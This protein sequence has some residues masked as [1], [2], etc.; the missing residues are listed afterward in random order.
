MIKEELR[1]GFVRL[2]ARKGYVIR[3]IG[4]DPHSEITGITVKIAD[5]DNYE[6]APMADVPPY[7]EAERKAKTVELIRER[8]DANKEFEVQRELLNAL[9]DPQAMTLDETGEDSGEPEAVRA[10]REYNRY[11]EQCIARAPQAVIAEKRQRKEAEARDA[12]GPDV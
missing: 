2:I 4:S 3:K 6:E 12:I 9:L 10:Y 8:Y 5:V 11:V 1:G 7:T